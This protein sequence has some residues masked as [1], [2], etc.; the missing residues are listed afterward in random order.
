MSQ[1]RSNTITHEKH[2]GCVAVLEPGAPW[3]ISVAGAKV[4][5]GGLVAVCARPGENDRDLLARVMASCAAQAKQGVET[6]TAILSCCGND[7]QRLYSRTRLAC[8]LL[9]KVLQP[10]PGRLVLVTDPRS[11]PAPNSLLGLAGVLLESLTGSG[12][13]VDVHVERDSSRRVAGKK[14]E[15]PGLARARLRGKRELETQAAY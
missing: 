2:S 14:L 8:E 15:G 3:P 13:S 11:G 9:S 12:V 1:A 6:K 5:Q 10:G 7:D 4:D